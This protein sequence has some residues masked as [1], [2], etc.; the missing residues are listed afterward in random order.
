VEKAFAEHAPDAVV[1][2]AAESH[3]DRAVVAPEEFLRTNVLGTFTM[4]DAARRAWGGRQG[5][6]FHHVS[7]DEV[8]GSLGPT[9]SFSEETP[10]A[11]RSPYSASKAGS[12][13]LVMA[14]HAT[15]GVPVTLSSCSNNYGPCQFPEKL[16][17]L[18]I[19]NMLDGRPLPVYGDGRNIR[20]W[21]HVEDHAAAV[22]KVMTEG[23]IGERYNVGGGNQWENIRLVRAL[24]AAVARQT[25]TSPADYERLITFV[26]DRPGHDRRYAI[27]SSKIARELGWRPSVTFEDGLERTVRWYIEHREWVDR[28][29]ARG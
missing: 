3:V 24:C 7:T 2:F 28:A 8:F 16:V 4:L 15:Y 19:L 26:T 5:T 27:D 25:G 29:R 14:W 9:G 22:W 10:Y 6:V 1:H 11:P 13:H 17:P 21:L 12:D 23:R 20:D 18:M